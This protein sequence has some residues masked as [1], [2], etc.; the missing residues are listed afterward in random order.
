MARYSSVVIP[1]CKFSA[2]LQNSLR[3]VRPCY[4]AGSCHRLEKAAY[5]GRDGRTSIAGWLACASQQA[6]SCIGSLSAGASRRP[7]RTHQPACTNA[8]RPITTLSRRGSCFRWAGH[9]AGDARPSAVLAD[10]N[11]TKDID[12]ALPLSWSDA[13]AAGVEAILSRALRAITFMPLRHERNEG[14]TT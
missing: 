3:R 4:D 13:P 9:V 7:G 5:R 6:C 2:S 12:R 14:F 8:L 10:H 1:D 11:W